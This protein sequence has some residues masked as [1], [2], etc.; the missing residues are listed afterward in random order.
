[1]LT[2]RDATPVTQTF[3]AWAVRRDGSR[4]VL[5]APVWSVSDTQLATI[6]GSGVLTASGLSAGALTVRV[7]G[8]GFDGSTLSA[9]ADVTI[10]LERTVVGP[11]VPAEIPVR[12]AGATASGSAAPSLL[13]PL[14]GAWMP[15]NVPPVD[16]Q[17]APVGNAGDVFRVRIEKP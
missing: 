15:N 1:T 2:V 8:P 17:W 11:G 3:T 12:I 13:Y 5:L 14:N 10:R 4:V 7:E 9:Q 6:N 16:V